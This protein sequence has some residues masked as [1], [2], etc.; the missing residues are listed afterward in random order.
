[1][2]EQY[3]SNRCL[4]NTL[5]IGAWTVKQHIS[6]RRLLSSELC[7]SYSWWHLVGKLGP[8]ANYLP[9]ALNMYNTKV[10]M[11]VSESRGHLQT[12]LENWALL[13]TNPWKWYMPDIIWW[14]LDAKL[15]HII[16]RLPLILS[17]TTA[18][19]VQL[20]FHVL[21]VC[22]QNIGAADACQGYHS[23]YIFWGS[24]LDTWRAL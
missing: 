5:V 10:Q 4:N 6:P 15:L 3:T 2:L 21:I 17:C 14:K 12:T 18:K 24:S 22:S 7:F 16:K 20:Y 9:K 8:V 23:T 11:V 13:Q 1:M 19:I